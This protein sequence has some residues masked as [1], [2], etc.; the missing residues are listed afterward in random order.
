MAPAVR[1]ANNWRTPA[2]PS[3]F[4][5]CHSN[6]ACHGFVLGWENTGA[7]PTCEVPIGSP[8]DTATPS[9]KNPYNWITND[10]TPTGTKKTQPTFTPIVLNHG[11]STVGDMGYGLKT[12]N[13]FTPVDFHT[14]P[15]VAGSIDAP[16]L[17]FFS[18]NPVDHNYPRE[19]YRRRQS[20]D[21]SYCCVIRSYERCPS[22]R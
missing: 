2:V 9:P 3:L 6:F 16:L 15:Q 13:L 18:Y 5:I 11:F 12:A 17:D 22:Y 10:G 14:Y 8:S 7:C 4:A 1:I 19:G 21:V 20:A